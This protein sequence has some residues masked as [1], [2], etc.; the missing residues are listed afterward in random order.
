MIGGLA[1][2]PQKRVTA[3]F[4]RTEFGNEP[5]R[6]W[7][8]TLSREDRQEI[9]V[10]VR[11]TENGW[12]IGMPTCDSLGEASGKSGPFGRSDRPHI[13][14]HGGCED[15]FAARNYQKSRT[16]AKVDLATARDRKRILTERLRHIDKDKSI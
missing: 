10:D 2:R 15:V 4:Y 13:F 7:L 12:P 11:K 8:K 5:V 16:S 3:E 9:G 6:E 14:L 1:G